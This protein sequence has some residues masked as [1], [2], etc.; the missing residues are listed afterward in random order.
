[1]TKKFRIRFNLPQLNYTVCTDGHLGEIYNNQLVKSFWDGHKD[2][3]L[4]VGKHINTL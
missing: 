3:D 4:M 2:T 1:M